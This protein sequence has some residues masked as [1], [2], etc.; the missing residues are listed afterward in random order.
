[1]IPDTL[2]GVTSDSGGGGR[3]SVDAA[4]PHGRKAYRKPA[5][6]ASPGSG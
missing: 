6:I 2:M 1:M 3:G 5:V 4:A